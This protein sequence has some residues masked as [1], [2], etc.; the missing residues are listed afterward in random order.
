MLRTWLITLSEP[1]ITAIDTLATLVIIGATLQAFV[2]ML[3][4]VVRRDSDT[5]HRRQILLTYGRWLVAALT[6][7]LAADII[8]SSIVPTWQAIGQLGAV[9]VI[10]TFLNYFLERDITEMRERQPADPGSESPTA[11]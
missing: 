2:G 1:A 11:T 8:E 4:L 5:C 9:A 3:T 7:Q 6:F 10:R